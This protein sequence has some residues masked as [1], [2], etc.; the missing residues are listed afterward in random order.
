MIRR[1]SP[2]IVRY[3]YQSH[4]RHTS[5]DELKESRSFKLEIACSLLLSLSKLFFVAIEL[6][7]KMVRVD[8]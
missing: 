2:E 8:C 4:K 1:F 7:N 3:C 6:V 5:D